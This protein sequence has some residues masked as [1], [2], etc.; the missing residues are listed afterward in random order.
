MPRE[1]GSRARSLLANLPGDLRLAPLWLVPRVLLGWFSLQAGWAIQQASPAATGLAGNQI[2]AAGLTL[3]G[4]ALILGLLTGPA[5]FVAGC[6]SFA[7]WAGQG[8]VIAALH[9]MLVL[10]L[11]LAW[12]SAGWFGLDR[13]VLP[14]LGLSGRGG[15][16]IG[17]NRSRKWR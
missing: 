9:G 17:E 13:W 14:L 3:A 12:K 5:A 16:L 2:M 15:A 6:L 10:W 11:M 7:S 8:V 4:I 1:T